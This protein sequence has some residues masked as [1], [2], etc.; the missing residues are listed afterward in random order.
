M[1]IGRLLLRIVVGGVFIGH[2][3]QKLT[4]AFD[5]PGLEGT[6]KMNEKLGMHPPE[7]NALAAA[8]SETLGGAAIVA[9]VA[10]PVATA[11]TTAA[12]AT[13]I[14]KVHA[15]NGFWNSKGGYE[16]NA[17]LIAATT[18]L[19]IDGPGPLSIDA[20]VGK[21]RWGV[22][23]GLLGLGAGVVASSFAIEAGEDAAQR[24]EA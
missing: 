10:M 22:F 18:A 13:A 9:G 14:R 6:A 15:R 1:G 19:T 24:A 8:L 12:M 20:L 16:Y 23:W 5:G 11:A 2:G 21:H 3:L 7:R 17:T 4:G